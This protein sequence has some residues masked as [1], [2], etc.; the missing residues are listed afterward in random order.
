LAR[1]QAKASAEVL[2]QTPAPAPNSEAWIKK[3]VVRE[4]KANHH[5]QAII[6]I[7]EA[8]TTLML[9]S[10]SD[11][12]EVKLMPVQANKLQAQGTFKIQP[13]IACLTAM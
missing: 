10:A 9:L 11:K 6:D 12:A 3:S 8:L 13:S 1:G 2:R 7:R 4:R 5:G